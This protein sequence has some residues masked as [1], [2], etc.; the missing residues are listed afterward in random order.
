[1]AAVEMVLILI[2]ENERDSSQ[3]LI[4]QLENMARQLRQIVIVDIKN[5]VHLREQ[6]TSK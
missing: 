4:M 2:A 5:F 1:M 3:A 6:L